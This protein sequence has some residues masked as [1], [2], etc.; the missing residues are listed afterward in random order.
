MPRGRM[1]CVTTHFIFEAERL[2]DR[3]AIMD[4]GK[5]ISCDSVANLRRHL[6]RYDSSVIQCG[7]VPEPLRREVSR[8]LG[9]LPQVVSCSFRGDRAEAAVLFDALKILRAHGIDIHAVDTNEP[10]LEEVFLN[11]VNSRGSS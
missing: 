1:P 9:A 5:I 6:Q 8:H 4:E 3:V 10:S 7:E 11:T 2:C